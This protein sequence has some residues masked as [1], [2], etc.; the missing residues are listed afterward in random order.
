MEQQ[1]VSE[2]QLV[3]FTRGGNITDSCGKNSL[4]GTSSGGVRV[5]VCGQ[6]FMFDSEGDD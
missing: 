5:C 2:L 3:C 1:C 6:S 4:G